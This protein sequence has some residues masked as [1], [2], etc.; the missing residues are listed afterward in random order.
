VSLH[1][2]TELVP[3]DRK[4]N[5]TAGIGTAGRTDDGIPPALARRSPVGRPSVAR[6]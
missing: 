3:A 6:R 4:R 1:G 2:L 5:G